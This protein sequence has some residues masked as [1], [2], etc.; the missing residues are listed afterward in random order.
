MSTSSIKRIAFRVR[1]NHIFFF[2]ILFSNYT[3][4]QPPHI[5]QLTFVT[6]IF[7]CILNSSLFCKIKVAIKLIYISYASELNEHF[8]FS[9]FFDVSKMFRVLKA[10]NA[11]KKLAKTQ[12]D[13]LKTNADTRFAYVFDLNMYEDLVY[14]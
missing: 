7:Q 12:T 13:M 3:S 9:T 11:Q 1:V 8:D 14:N 10:K 2:E 6:C 5:F 4:A